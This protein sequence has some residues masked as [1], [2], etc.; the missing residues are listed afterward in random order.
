MIGSAEAGV[1]EHA[2]L[3]EQDQAGEQPAVAIERGS[4]GP[5]D[6][7]H[8]KPEQGR[9]DQHPPQMQRAREAEHRL[10]QPGAGQEQRVQRSGPVL[11]VALGWVDPWLARIEPGAA[12]VQLQYA[13]EAHVSIGIGEPAVEHRNDPGQREQSLHQDQAAER[14]RDQ[15]AERRL[16]RRGASEGGRLQCHRW[17]YRV[18]RAGRTMAA[19][20]LSLR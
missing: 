11:D 14:D 9:A 3:G 16:V 4:G 18:R 19:V 17:S 1:G 6:R 10:Q 2:R 13:H 5:G 7:D 15:P 20:R 8:G 12:V